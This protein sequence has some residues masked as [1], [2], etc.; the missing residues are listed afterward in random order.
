MTDAD[1]AAEL[2]SIADRVVSA[3]APGEAL[4]V[5]VS[6]SCSTTVRVHGGEVES[7]TVADRSG[8]GV[9]VIVD[10]RLG[11]ASAGSLEPEVVDEVVTEAR[12][13]VPYAGADP[14]VRLPEPDGVEPPKLDLWDDAVRSTATERKLAL[15]LDL[16]RQVMAGDRRVTGIRTASYSDRAVTSVVAGT[17]GLFAPAN[18]TSAGLG[19]LAIARDGE[20]TQSGAGSSFGRGPG[21][22]SVAEAAGHAVE[23]ATSLLGATQPSS[24]R[25]TLVLEPRMAS[26]VLGVIGGMLGGDRVLKGRTPFADRLGDAIA[27]PGFSMIDDPT[28]PESFGA[29]PYDGEG[30]ATRANPL[31]LDGVLQQ[32]LHDTTTGSRAGTAS[33]ASA[34]RSVRSTPAPGWQALAVAA[35]DA[36]F[37][38]LIAG[39]DEGLLVQSLA[40]LHSGVNPVSGDFSVG[41]EGIAIRHGEL[42]EPVR[43]ATIAS[44]LP[45]LLLDIEG[46]G[47]DIEHRPGGVSCPAMTIANVSLSGS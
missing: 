35:R 2:A 22:L 30:L 10:G 28:R 4:E 41:V 34:V 21:D 15:A 46:L 16:E 19:V 23:R 7:L 13:N 20:Q 43:E 32:F 11:F 31:V 8:I 25:I 45:R 47:C 5:A 14:H 44:T 6:R 36:S 18:S 17:S 27:A 40:G 29:G 9:R 38:E 39:V 37:E 24:R 3:A 42:A 12:A 33:T 26:S 1:T